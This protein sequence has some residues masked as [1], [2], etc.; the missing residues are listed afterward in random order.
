MTPLFLY[1]RIGCT[2][3]KSSLKK[4]LK[5]QKKNPYKTITY[6]VFK[7]NACKVHQSWYNSCI[8]TKQKETK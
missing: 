3:S 6:R 5:I 7:D 2:I 8:L 4:M 1:K